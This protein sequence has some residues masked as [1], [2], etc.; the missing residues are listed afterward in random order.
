MSGAYEFGDTVS[1]GFG[2]NFDDASVNVRTDRFLPSDFFNPAS[3]SFAP[4]DLV[5]FQT[6][7]GDETDV[8]YTAGV[9]WHTPDDSFSVGATYKSGTAFS[10]RVRNNDA[11]T[12]E[13]FPPEAGRDFD[14]SATFHVPSRAGV[15]IAWKRDTVT[16]LFDVT[17]VNYSELT[18]DLAILFF[19]SAD[20]STVN[21]AFQMEDGNEIRFGGEWGITAV[22]SSLFFVRGGLWLDP[23]HQLT[24]ANQGSFLTATGFDNGEFE[25]IVFPDGDYDAWHYTVG[26]GV[27][28]GARMQVDVAFD[29]SELVTSTNA[30]VV[31]RF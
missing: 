19:T 5:N 7:V 31:V 18:S 26:G 17:R 15:G 23:A 12:G 1:V 29:Y 11:D 27:A 20:V 21:Q 14:Q 3:V 16:L 10:L 2:L 13:P 6:Q 4:D 8:G 22:G 9:R 30:S 24:F 28:V 25:R